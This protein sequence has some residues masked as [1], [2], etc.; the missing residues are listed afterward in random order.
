MYPNRDMAKVAEEAQRSR[1]SIWNIGGFGEWTRRAEAYDAWF[2]EQRRKRYEQHIMKSM[3]ARIKVATAMQD[4]LSVEFNR[5]MDAPEE[6]KTL[7]AWTKLGLWKAA[8]EVENQA[9]G[10]VTDKGAQDGG[11]GSV[12][13]VIEEVDNW[14]SWGNTNANGEL[15]RGTGDNESIEG[16]YVE[17]GSGQPMLRLQEPTPIDA[18][19][20]KRT[21]K[22][23]LPYKSKP[24]ASGGTGYFPSGKKHGRPPGA[25]N[26]P[27]SADKNE[28]V[29]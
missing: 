22:P 27:K 9:L 4:S 7:S 25:K 11:D 19:S 1:N 5:I 10:I 26:K 12:R 21:K 23:P 13:V 2:A 8:I 18:K 3:E 6:V 17:A 20:N 16:E 29:G 15:E 24:A 28:A 14:R